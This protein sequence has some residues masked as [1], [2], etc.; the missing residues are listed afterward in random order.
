MSDCIFCKIANKQMDTKLITETDDY[1][2]FNDISPQAPIHALVIPKKHFSSLNDIEDIEL[3]G[4]LV[5][6]V[7]EIAEKLGVKDNYRTIINTGAEAGQAVF[8][9][10]IHIMAGRPLL[11]PPG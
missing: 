6:G 10:H 3:M 9:M 2:A 4:K 11:W 7:K 5:Q 1:V 8:H